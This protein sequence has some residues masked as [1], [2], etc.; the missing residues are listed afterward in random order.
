M[1]AIKK[2]MFVLAVFVLVVF[3]QYYFLH[4]GWV[5]HFCIFSLFLLLNIFGDEVIVC[6]CGSTV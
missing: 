6:S 5:V 1:G 4:C 3:S 2:M